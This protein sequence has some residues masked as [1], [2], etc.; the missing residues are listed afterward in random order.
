VLLCHHSASHDR[1]S[2]SVLGEQLV[3]APGPNFW[4]GRVAA[5]PERSRRRVAR[6]DAEVPRWYLLPA[7]HLVAVLC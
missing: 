2:F 4:E 5:A 7:G 6:A 1:F 3:H